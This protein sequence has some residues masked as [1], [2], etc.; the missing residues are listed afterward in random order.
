MGIFLF[1][2]CYSE[3]Y[4]FFA[5]FIFFKAVMWDILWCYFILFLLFFCLFVCFLKVSADIQLQTNVN[6][7]QYRIGV[8]IGPRILSNSS[9]VAR[10]LNLYRRL[11]FFVALFIILFFQLVLP[12]QWIHWHLSA[13][14]VSC[15]KMILLRKR[16]TLLAPFVNIL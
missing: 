6:S 4:A 11:T 2:K 16:A 5:H 10:E 8:C 1:V 15:I 12:H 14:F 3:N 13:N 9:T 7:S